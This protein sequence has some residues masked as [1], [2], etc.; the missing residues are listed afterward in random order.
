MARILESHGAPPERLWIMPNGVDR[1][2]FHPGIDGAPVRETLGLQHAF[3]LGFVGWVRSWH[4]VDYLVRAAAELRARIPDLV[5]LVVGDGPARPE[6]ETLAGELGVSDQVLFTGAVP[7]DRIPEYI[8]AMDVAV[9]PNV[10]EYA[11]PIK[12]FEYLAMARPVIAPAKDNITEIVTHGEHALLFEPGSTA[13]LAVCIES[14]YADSELRAALGQCAARLIEE[15]EYTWKGNANRVAAIA[16][17][18]L[19]RLA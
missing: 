16:G 12:L 10:T 8:A 11:S 14:L 17:A 19:E 2:R 5:V 15:R 18:P 3:V 13:Q 9:Q 1:T 6:L 7:Q 4:G